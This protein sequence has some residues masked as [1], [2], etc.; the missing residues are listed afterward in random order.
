MPAPPPKSPPA[1]RLKLARVTPWLYLLF[2]AGVLIQVYLA[3]YGIENLGAQGMDLHID[4]AH[5]IEMIPLLIIVVGFL[6][7]DWRA[8]V[9]GV[10][11]LALFFGQYMSLGGLD[12]RVLALHAFN[13]VLIA[14]VTMAFLMRRLPWKAL[15]QP[16]PAKPAQPAARPP[17]PKA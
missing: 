12:A 17:S 6:S 16:V 15:P 13:G 5:A 10:V 7:I 11:L 9:G 3:G 8:G 14:V 4:L 1:W 2:L